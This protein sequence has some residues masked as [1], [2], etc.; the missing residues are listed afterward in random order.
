MV[1]M[2][3][4]LNKNDEKENK[5]VTKSFQ[6][7][8]VIRKQTATEEKHVKAIVDSCDLSRDTILKNAKNLSN[9]GF[10][11]ISTES[12][13]DYTYV[14]ITKEGVNQFKRVDYVLNDSD[15]ENSRIKD[16]KI[17]LFI[18]RQL[19]YELENRFGFEN[20]FPVNVNLDRQKELD[21]EEV[22]EEM[23]K[24]ALR[25]SG[26]G[27]LTEHLT[28][29]D[30]NV[31][32]RKTELENREGFVKW[33]ETAFMIPEPFRR[34]FFGKEDD[35]YVMFREVPPKEDTSEGPSLW[36]IMVMYARH[37]IPWTENKIRW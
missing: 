2:Y 14:K 33:K 37:Y 9:K 17:R 20:V 35:N 1:N 28:K 5:G 27:N 29:E 15:G 7:F 8:K 12:K 31:D 34:R 18:L 36:D 11:N 4:K 32:I 24:D 10:V 19:K 26:L 16:Q 30:L 6:A 23:E 13:Q 22:R 21:M 25:L 3:E